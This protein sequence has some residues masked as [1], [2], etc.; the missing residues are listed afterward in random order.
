MLEDAGPRTG[1]RTSWTCVGTRTEPAGLGRQRGGRGFGPFDHI[2][3]QAPLDQVDGD[4][5]WFKRIGGRIPALHEQ[6]CA[7]AEGP[8]V[9]WA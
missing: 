9:R 6:A 3:Y 4:A 7:A 2:W 1:V 5:G 8:G